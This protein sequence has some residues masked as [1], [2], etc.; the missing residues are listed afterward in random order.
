ML[1]SHPKVLPDPARIRFVEFGSYSLD[2]DVFAYV[3]VTDFGE[4]LEIAEDLNLRIMAI[5]A[6]SGTELAVP[7]QVEYQVAKGPPDKERMQRTEAQVNKW[8]DQQALYLPSFPNE[9]IA[10]L[11]DSLDYP[12]AGSPDAKSGPRKGS[13]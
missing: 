10:E 4:F 9:K 2:L 11:A 7:A 1:Y 3:D 12:P 5:V 8:R 13:A 6:E